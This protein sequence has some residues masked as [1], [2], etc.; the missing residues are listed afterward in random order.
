VAAWLED[1][2]VAATPEKKMKTRKFALATVVAAAALGFG[3][4]A[5]AQYAFS[6]GEFLTGDGVPTG[7]ATWAT[8]SIDNTSGYQYTFTLSLGTNFD[9]IFGSQSYVNEAFFNA[10]QFGTVASPLLIDS[11][12]VS[13]ISLVNGS[14]GGP[15]GIFEFG[16]KFGQNANNRLSAG[17]TVSWS[18]TFSS[19]LTLISP[20]VGLKVQ[21][22]GDN[23]WS[24]TYT[25]TT[26]IPEPETY[27]MLLA[28]LGLL[29]FARRRTTRSSAAPA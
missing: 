1:E 24:A 3:T 6:F 4:P 12:G 15:T 16:D 17:E 20:E 5:S 26:P 9:D 13:S 14:N 8:M 18:Q 29:V 11:S 10:S 21:G 19:A 25:P 22:I 2:I 7:G 27:A 23:D 28:G